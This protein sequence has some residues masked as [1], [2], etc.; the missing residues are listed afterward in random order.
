MDDP[1]GVIS[2]LKVPTKYKQLVLV[3]SQSW[4]STVGILNTYQRSGDQ[5]NLVQGQIP[6][7]FGAAGLGWGR[8]LHERVATG[9]RKREGDE[10]APAGIFLLGPAFRYEGSPSVTTS[11]SYKT[12]TSRDYFV[13]DPE[14]T[15]YNTWVHIPDS[16]PN[17]PSAKWRSFEVMRRPDNAYELGVVVQHNMNPVSRGAGSAIFLHIWKGPSDPTTGCTAMSKN[18]I[19]K[20]IHWLDREETPILVQAPLPVLRNLRFAH[21]R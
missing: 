4:S 13:D 3:T 16:E 9:P 6:V 8:G 20:L 15:A 12:I 5:W 2:T 11:L 1:A 7:V 17:T 21:S 19:G 14:S 10:R 18:N